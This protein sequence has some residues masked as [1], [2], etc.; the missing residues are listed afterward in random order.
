M[1]AHVKVATKGASKWVAS[2]TSKRAKAA[3]D[4]ARSGLSGGEKC[5]LFMFEKISV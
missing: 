4:Q 5:T 1:G 2:Q 3:M